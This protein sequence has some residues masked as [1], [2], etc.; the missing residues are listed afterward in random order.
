MLAAMNITSAIRFTPSLSFLKVVFKMER[1]EKF[2]EI[3]KNKPPA[4][5]FL[6][7]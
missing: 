5:S 3:F 2:E 1:K 7:L 4:C 6:G